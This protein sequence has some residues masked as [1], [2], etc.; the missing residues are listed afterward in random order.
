MDNHWPLSR[1]ST[2]PLAHSLSGSRRRATPPVH[3]EP[4]SGIPADTN[5]QYWVDFTSPGFN[6]R[7]DRGLDDGVSRWFEFGFPRSL[8]SR[9]HLFDKADLYARRSE[10]LLEIHQHGSV[11]VRHERSSPPR[12][13]TTRKAN[14]YLLAG[15]SGNAGEH[16]TACSN[17][18]LSTVPLGSGSPPRWSANYHDE[19]LG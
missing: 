12:L 13:M 2:N 18:S 11:H 17:Y 4:L 14:L 7:V 15:I 1:N 3:W 16:P 5:G 19:Y 8:S 9:P 10:A 6:T